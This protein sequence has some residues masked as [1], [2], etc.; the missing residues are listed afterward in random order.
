MVNIAEAVKGEFAL[1]LVFLML[2]SLGMSAILLLLAVSFLIAL[3]I[4]YA[5]VQIQLFLSTFKIGR[6]KSE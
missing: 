4:A 6:E 5:F 3:H 1:F 2:A